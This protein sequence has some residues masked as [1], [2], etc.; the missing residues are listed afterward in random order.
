M[1]RKSKK[2][3]FLKNSILKMLDADE[4]ESNPLFLSLQTTFRATYEIAQE[5]CCTICIP[6]G[7]AIEG[8]RKL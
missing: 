3:I 6:Q 7:C 2:K 8:K 4:L 1:R 5:Q